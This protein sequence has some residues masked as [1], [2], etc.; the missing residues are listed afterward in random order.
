MDLDQASRNALGW[1]KWVAD[2]ATVQRHRRCNSHCFPFSYVGALLTHG[3]NATVRVI[4]IGTEPDAKVKVSP[5]TMFTP[6]FSLRI[7]NL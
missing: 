7:L 5:I 2:L 6:C 4:R 3:N 1:W